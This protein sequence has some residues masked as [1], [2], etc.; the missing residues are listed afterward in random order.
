M[1]SWIAKVTTNPIRLN[2][3]RRIL[4][5]VPAAVCL[6][7]LSALSFLVYWVA[8]NVR[9]RIRM[10][11]EELLPEVSKKELARHVRNYFL[12]LILA[13]Y[14]ILVD[15]LRLKE[16]SEARFMV[17]GEEY[18][19]EALKKGRGVILYAPHMGNFFYYYWVLTK[20][21]DCL[22]VATGGS[23]ELRPLYLLFQDLG[24]SGLD[25]DN[26]PPLQL[27]RTLREHLKKNGVVFLLGDFWRPNFPEAMMFGRKTRTPS[28]A[29]VLSLDQGAPVIPFYGYRTQGWK[30]ELVFG[31]PIYLD[32]EFERQQ[33]MEAMNRLNREM[34]KMI[35]NH[36]EQWFYWFNVHERWEKDCE[37][38]TK[39]IAS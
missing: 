22:T 7:V 24:C 16:P 14:E 25:Y 8:G 29:A 12:N 28:G 2:R 39:M 19:K 27:L 20:K 35:R 37:S 3:L 36:P 32:Q 9:K 1:Y 6:P 21:Y 10:N 34:E 30:H 38:Q 13:L 11:M 26:T 4:G 15:S 17:H 33:R 23:P 5:R 31:P 18:L